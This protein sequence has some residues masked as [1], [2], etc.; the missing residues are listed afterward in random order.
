MEEYVRAIENDL[1]VLRETVVML[2]VDQTNVCN[3]IQSIEDN[4]RILQEMLSP[5]IQNIRTR[6]D[7]G[8]NEVN[9]I[10]LIVKHLNNP[11]SPEGIAL[12]EQFQ[13]DLH[14][15]IYE[16][17]SR[18]GNN[19][20][21]HNDFEVYVGDTLESAS[22]KR[23][24]HKSSS[25][26][27]KI[28]DTQR[29]WTAG[30]QFLNEIASKFVPG[31]K[32]ARLWYDICIITGL[33]DKYTGGMEPPSFEDWC[34]NDAFCQGDPKTPF[35]KLLKQKVREILGPKTS[36]K[37]D[38]EYPR[39]RVN[40]VFSLTDEE[41]KEF[42]QEVLPAVQKCLS[43]KDIWLTIHGSI[44]E[45]R[46]YC[47]WYPHFNIRSIESVEV[48]TDKADIQFNFV[49][50]DNQGN[51]FLFKAILRWGKGVGFSNL[52]IDFK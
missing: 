27:T 15:N 46:F 8:K 7:N 10:D 30:V 38:S 3:I 6:R 49:S 21:T 34:K 52:R 14:I 5:S 51:P 44:Q 2:P 37:D 24:E 20:N 4:L 36:L 22:W 23:V 28:L 31:R 50:T 47:K 42:I 17:R 33:F 9:D 32:Y 13:T 26:Y 39:K 19:R 43:Q 11:D 45:S 29:P 18:N 48:I 40:S 16:A 35:G 41:K 1:Q 25:K 12:R